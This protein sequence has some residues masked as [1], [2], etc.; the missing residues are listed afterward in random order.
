D[1]PAPPT[2]LEP[3]GA[4][5]DPAHVD[6]TP[7]LTWTH[8]G[9]AE[10]G[11]FQ[12]EIYDSTNALIHD[13]GQVTSG[14]ASYQ[15][16]AGILEWGQTYS[17]RVR[18]WDIGNAES[19]WSDPVYI[20]TLGAPLA[21]QDLAPRDSQGVDASQ[22]I[23]LSWTHVSP[24][25]LP[26]AA[27]EVEVY[28]EEQNLIISTGQ[29]ASQN[30]HHDLAA[31]TLNNGESYM[32]RVRTWV[33]TPD[34]PGQWSPLVMFRGSRPP[35]VTITAPSAGAYDKGIVSV[36]WTFSDPDGD[37]Q[38]WYRARLLRGGKVVEDSGQI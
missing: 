38:A 25:G 37:P 12:V 13:S 24:Q 34:I 20:E 6:L 30:Q 17:W 26:Q 10:Q 29:V 2:D 35:A 5:S 23:R 27:Y 9:L 16:P 8:A 18:T 4:S 15:V 21:P 33:A 14:L 19:P 11:R 36:S 7:T 28:D 1:A 22:V 32:W 3:G 31:A